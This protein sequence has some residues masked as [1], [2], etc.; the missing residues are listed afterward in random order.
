MFLQNDDCFNEDVEYKNPLSEADRGLRSSQFRQSTAFLLHIAE[1]QCGKGGR[2]SIW[3]TNSQ[4][5]FGVVKY[6]SLKYQ[7]PLAI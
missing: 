7:Q 5:S 4:G 1:F 3:S 6:T 2:E